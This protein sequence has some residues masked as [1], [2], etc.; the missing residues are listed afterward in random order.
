MTFDLKPNWDGAILRELELILS[1]LPFKCN[2]IE[3][4]FKLFVSFV[5]IAKAQLK[6]IN[7]PIIGLSAE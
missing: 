5:P 1:P 7:D 3:E 2:L 4:R 6:A